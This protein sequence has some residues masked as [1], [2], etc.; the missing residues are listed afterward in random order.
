[1]IEVR[2]VDYNWKPMG[3]IHAPLPRRGDWIVFEGKLYEAQTVW[4]YDRKTP[5]VCIGM[6]FPYPPPKPMRE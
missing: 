4:I 5:R 6:A 1:M 3:T 2:L